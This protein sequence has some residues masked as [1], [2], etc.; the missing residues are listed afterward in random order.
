MLNVIDNWLNSNKLTFLDKIQLRQKRKLYHFNCYSKQQYFKLTQAYFNSMPDCYISNKS[1][2]ISFETSGTKL[3]NA[4]F[5]K[6]VDDNTLVISS[7]VE[8]PSVVNQ[9]NKVKNK[10]L[11][12]IFDKN[13]NL[14][15]VKQQL[16]YFNKVFIYVIGTHIINGHY[17][18]QQLFI[19]LRKLTK[20]KKTVMVLDDVQGM[21]LKARDYSIFD[22][23]L[24]TAH[25]LIPNYDMGILINNNNYPMLGKKYY[26]WGKKHLK[27]VNK[28]L[29][30]KKTLL[31]FNTILSN[32]FVDYLKN[33]K[34]YKINTQDVYYLFH[35]I[36][37][38][39]QFTEKDENYIHKHYKVAI[40]DH[41]VIRFRAAFFMIY[42][43]LLK[44]AI[45]YVKQ[46]LEIYSKKNK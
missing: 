24:G 10:V 16:K 1:Y 29:Q 18:D 17:T 4:L 43:Q 44:Q 13:I 37:T 40:D 5:N 38:I 14:K 22:Y 6:Y 12:N 46:L 2:S 28:I 33:N 42:P 20:N 9:L 3:I 45:N 32:Y 25:A 30:H 34:Q 39:N 41:R 15:E 26:Y 23:I 8:H 21:F 35:I 27:L 7:N 36:N 31:S 19:K 11:L